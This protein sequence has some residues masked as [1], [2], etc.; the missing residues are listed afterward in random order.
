[1][2]T[3]KIYDYK[4]SIDCFGHK[5]TEDRYIVLD[6][7]GMDEFGSNFTKE[8]A[9]KLCKELNE[10]TIVYT[11]NAKTENNKIMNTN[12]DNTINFMYFISNYPHEFILKVWEG[13]LGEHL[14]TKFIMYC[15]KY[16]RSDLALLKWF[17]ELDFENQTILLSWVNENYKAFKQ[18]TLSDYKSLN[19]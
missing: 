19:N 1:M 15:N 10:E 2:Y 4:G 8:E 16:E 12:H 7:Q 11:T 3:T 14:N 6:P 17:Y 9:M 18:L 13:S 5:N